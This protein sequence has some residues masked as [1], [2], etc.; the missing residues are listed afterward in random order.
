MAALAGITRIKSDDFYLNS[1]KRIGIIDPPL[2]PPQAPPRPQ[3]FGKKQ[4]KTGLVFKNET[5]RSGNWDRGGEERRVVE[6]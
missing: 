4:H 3:A 1:A 2:H 6:S 5:F